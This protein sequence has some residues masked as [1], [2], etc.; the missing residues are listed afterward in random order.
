MLESLE[1]ASALLSTDF[2]ISVIIVILAVIAV[3]IKIVP[4]IVKWFKVVKT[5]VDQ[6]ENLK[7]AV[8]KNTEDI[9]IINTK[10]D[11]DYERLDEL[12]QITIKQQEY[13][14]DSLEERELIIHSLLG[15]VQGLQEVGA[16]GPTKKAEAEIQAYLVKKSHKPKN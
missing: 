6:Y 12:Q 2:V 16:D 13:I 4:I 5:A 8:E 14:E 10:I 9:K 11:R 1:K 15:V 7:V 3:L